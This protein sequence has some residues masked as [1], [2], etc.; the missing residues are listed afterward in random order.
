VA[1]S[2]TIPVCLRVTWPKPQ[3]CRILSPRASEARNH[4]RCQKTQELKKHGH[5]TRIQQNG[6]Y[7][8]AREDDAGTVVSGLDDSEYRSSPS[9]AKPVYNGLD[10]SAGPGVCFRPVGKSS[11]ARDNFAGMQGHTSPRNR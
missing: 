11:S 3:D 7:E 2:H 4:D 6:G 9:N 10:G 5:L 1:E 8:L